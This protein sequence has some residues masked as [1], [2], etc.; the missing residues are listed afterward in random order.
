MPATESQRLDDMMRKVEAMLATA[1]S[2]NDTNP[3]AAA[4]YRANAERVMLK[5]RIAQEDLIARGGEQ[6][7]QFGI[8]FHD[9]TAYLLGSEFADVYRVLLSY[10][11]KHVGARLVWNGYKAEDNGTFRVGT[12]VG[13]E[14][15]IRYA[16]ALFLNARLVFADRMEPQ[17]DPNLSD[18]DN[19]YRMRM[20]G[21]ERSRIGLIM[22][23]GG[24]GTKGP[25]KATTMFKR[26]CKARGEDASALLGKGNSVK[27][28]RSVYADEFTNTIWY[29]LWDAQMAVEKESGGIVLHGR[30]ER[31]DEAVYERW[32]Y[33]RP[34]PPERSL[35]EEPRR[36]AKRQAADERR[37]LREA[38]KNAERKNTRAGQAG[39]RA[40]K[41]AADEVAINKG[42]TTRRIEN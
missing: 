6:T 10:V 17:R 1:E 15:D 7:D 31:I 42:A 24:E 30:K 13:Y 18:E 3:E 27:N 22:G 37:W 38:M 21:M 35:G 41:A 9:I 16:E 32:S 5:Y 2:L 40:G 20:A 4:N 11:T 33:L 39:A 23:W 19:V 12:L 29:R 28:F 26:A 34:V 14:A 8:Q 25:G 36:S